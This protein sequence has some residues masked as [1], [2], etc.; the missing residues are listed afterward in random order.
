MLWAFAKGKSSLL[1]KVTFLSLTKNSRYGSG[2]T[3]KPYLEFHLVTKNHQQIVE[4]GKYMR[5]LYR[6]AYRFVEPSASVDLKS[7]HT[8]RFLVNSL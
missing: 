6:F 4:S 7:E 5:L 2:K 1:S 8:I 3:V